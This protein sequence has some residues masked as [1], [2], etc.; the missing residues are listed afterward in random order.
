MFVN[1]GDPVAAGLVQSIARPGGNITGI[2]SLRFELAS[3]RMQVLKELAPAVRR[4]WIIYD[5]GDPAAPLVVR[6]AE[7]AAPQLGVELVARPVGTAQELARALAGLGPGDGV[8][9]HDGPTLLD[10]SAQILKASQSARV[11]VI[12]PSPFWLQW[13]ALVSYGPDYYAMGHQAARLVARILRGAT[14]ADLPVEGANKIPLVINLKAARAIGLTI[15]RSLL[16]R[17]DELIQ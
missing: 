11:P 17:A 12:F 1:V 6:E 9:I 14:P 4:V 8:M 13:G 7:V 10:I 15:P 5:V 2:S 3:K 16:L